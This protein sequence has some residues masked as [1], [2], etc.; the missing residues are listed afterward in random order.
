MAAAGAACT[1]AF[2][3]LF[4]V[5]VHKVRHGCENMSAIQRKEGVSNTAKTLSS[6]YPPL[7]NRLFV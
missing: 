1:G 2:P 6:G 3:V 5:R 4:G 7:G